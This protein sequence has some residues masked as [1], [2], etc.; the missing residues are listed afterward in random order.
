MGTI[1]RGVNGPMSGSSCFISVDGLRFGLIDA[2]PDSMVVL[3][4]SRGFSGERD[5]PKE[6]RVTVREFYS[7]IPKVA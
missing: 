5:I 2:D 7:V 6:Y 4:R 1:A 3:A